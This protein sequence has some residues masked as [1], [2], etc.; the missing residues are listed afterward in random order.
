MDR[1]DH[2]CPDS[3]AR[4]RV[5]FRIWHPDIDPAIISNRLQ[6]NPA[7]SWRAGEARTNPDGQ[8]LGGQNDRSYW[9]VR[10]EQVTDSAELESQLM[11]FVQ[12][13]ESNAD[14]LDEIYRT[15]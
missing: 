11:M 1:G 6:L 15:G 5:S 14:L 7:R 4:C 10:V 3:E 9:S 13:L 12:T 2:M 8:L